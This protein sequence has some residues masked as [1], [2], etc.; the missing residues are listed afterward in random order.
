M[1]DVRDVAAQL[2]RGSHALENASLAGKRVLVR[3]DFNV[4]VAEDKSVADWTRVDAALPTIRLLLK[5]GAH[6]VL[7][8]HLGRPQPS[9][10]STEDMKADFSMRLIEPKLHSELGDAFLGVT[11]SAVGP[12]ASTAVEAIQAG[13]VRLPRDP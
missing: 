2:L 12:E 3:V 9:T 7:L 5:Q 11:D 4:P 8:S 6:V 1:P 13:Q 10:M